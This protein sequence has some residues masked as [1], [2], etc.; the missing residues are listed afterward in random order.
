[1]SWSGWLR[2]NSEHYLLVDAHER[3]AHRH[4]ASSP[5]PPRGPKEIFWLRVFAPVYHALPWSV[6]HRVLKAMP[7][8][9]RKTWAPPPRRRGPAV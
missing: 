8:S 2:A 6:R 1:M 7:G 3:L 5:R 4:G 9:H